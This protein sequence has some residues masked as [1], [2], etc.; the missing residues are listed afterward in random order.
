MVKFGERVEA[1]PALPGLVFLVRPPRTYTN[2]APVGC[3]WDHR[4]R[5]AD[6][7]APTFYV[8]VCAVRCVSCVCRVCTCVSWA[9]QN[10]M[11]AKWEQK[12]ALEK[13]AATARAGGHGFGE[14]APA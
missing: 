8:P 4:P 9:T 10:K 12:A 2:C 11:K 5:V 7:F 6:T 14:H 1:P 13:G 3:R